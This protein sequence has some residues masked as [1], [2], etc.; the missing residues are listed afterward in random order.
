MSFTQEF[1][2]FPLADMP[3]I[4]AGFKDTSWRNDA[5]P[6]FF[7]A[8]KRLGIYIDYA[9]KSQREFEAERFIIFKTDAEGLPIGDAIAA[10]ESWDVI[11]ASLKDQS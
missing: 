5:C 8:I 3:V 7:D 6:Y 11:L 4:P 1:P 9:D 10:S 2:D